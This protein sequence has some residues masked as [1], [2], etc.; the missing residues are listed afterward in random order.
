MPRMPTPHL[1]GRVT[2]A[3]KNS[4]K[5]DGDTIHLRDPVL[6]DAAGIHRPKDGALVVTMPG[7]A[8]KALKLRTKPSFSY[9]TIRLSG[10]DA[11]EENYRASTTELGGR[12]YVSRKGQPERAQTQWSPATR[13]L[14]DTLEQSQWTLVELDR[15]VCDRYGRVL[16]FVFASTARAAKEKFLTLE[17]LRRGLAFPFVFE[18]AGDYIKAFLRAGARA[19]TARKGVWKSY[20]DG[21]LPYSAAVP[22]PSHFTDQ[23]PKEQLALPL[24]LPMVFRWVVDCEQLDGGLTLEVALR[25]YDC[26]DH[27]TG[28]LFPGD[29]FEKIPIDQRIWAPHEY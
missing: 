27:T 25:K 8:P 2:Y 26:I 9:L 24:N 23:E 14:V 18:S 28:D 7:K 19:R 3:D 29:Q 1:F 17:L 11:P 12:R 15:D 22:A 10:I 5:P 13:F 6:I 20:E 21:P 16:G 4:F